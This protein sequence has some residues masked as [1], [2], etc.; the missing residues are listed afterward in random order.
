MTPKQP[1]GASL[2]VRDDPDFYV[3][4]P[5]GK[6]WA[7]GG[8]VATFDGYLIGSLVTERLWS[9]NFCWYR[10]VPDG[11]TRGCKTSRRP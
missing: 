3:W 2:M 9:A 6:C 8:V 7:C 10:R 1:P 11:M 4:E 5:G